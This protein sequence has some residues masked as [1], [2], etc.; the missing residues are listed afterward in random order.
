MVDYDGKEFN[1][2]VLR[3]VQCDKIVH[4][5][6]LST[7]GGCCHCGNKR[8]KNVQGLSPE[9]FYG[10]KHGTLKI[11]IEIPY[12]IDDGFLKLFE[13]VGEVPNE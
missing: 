4:R 5:A 2:P 8:V 6:F 13:E 12:Q 10:L 1:D 7:H 9:E 3:C 11:G